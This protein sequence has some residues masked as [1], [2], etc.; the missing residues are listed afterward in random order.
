M[1]VQCPQCSAAYEFPAERLPDEGLRAKCA[2]CGCIMRVRPPSG[3]GKVR[4][5]QSSTAP[6]RPGRA[7]SAPEAA[8]AR[9]SAPPT[10]QA[11]PVSRSA[12]SVP[13]AAVEAQPPRST[14]R[15]ELD[16]GDDEPSIII[17]MGQLNEMAA[18]ADTPAPSA[19]STA[20]TAAPPVSLFSP[21]SSPTAVADERQRVRPEAFPVDT[22][23][24]AELAASLRRRPVARMLVPVL[25]LL[26]GGFALFVAWRNNF[27]PIWQAPGAAVRHALGLPAAVASTPNEAVVEEAANHGEL[28][29][30][31]V[32]L[33]WLDR[34]V[35]LVR[36]LVVNESDRIQRSIGIEV[37]VVRDGLAL[38]SRVVPCCTD[39]DD[40]E[41][42]KIAKDSRH[43][44][45][46]DDQR[47]GEMALGPGESRTFAVILRDVPAAAREQ[48]Q[49][50]AR[51]RYSEAD[52][53]QAP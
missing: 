24:D 25:V 14:Q 52:R 23:V 34:T 30:R 35:A 3:D 50:H 42:R 51:I 6:R 13:P 43:P 11:P 5:E 37:G 41:A 47:T 2:R 8:S 32:D 18:P 10:A 20:L 33:V 46:T 19:D 21:L 39:F 48:A 15:R 9:V 12:A 44:H 28:V 49:P 26:V 7:L 29:V 27:G 53:V 45:F 1:L 40:E 16:E 31:Q 17:D 38:R 4:V 22:A 36:G